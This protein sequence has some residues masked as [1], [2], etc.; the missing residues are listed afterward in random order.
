[1]SANVDPEEVQAI[2]D[3]TEP[4]QGGPPEVQ[5]RD[6]ARPIRLSPK[7][8]G[9][10]EV[11]VRRVL[12]EVETALA[13]ALRERR[14]LNLIEAGEVNSESTFEGLAEPLAAVRF[15]VGGQPAWLVW[16]LLPALTAVEVALG[17]GE[18]GLAEERPFSAVE[19]KV[20]LRLAGPLIAAVCG[21]LNLAPAGLRVPQTREDLGSWRD[22]GPGADRR[23]L[24]L[25]L[26]LDGPGAPS[27]LR[28]Y[29]PGIDPRA[30]S[31]S[32]PPAALPAHLGPIKIELAAR[33]GANDIPL[34]Q[35]LSLEPGDVIPLSAPAG[36]PLRVYFEDRLRA[37]GVLG[38]KHGHLALRITSVGPE[39]EDI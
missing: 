29:L 33:L 37:H 17:A 26:E 14:A 5:P 18:P 38:S 16:E 6:F 30:P 24:L 23:R 22:G 3:L 8:L 39:D 4:P 20:L 9:A 15:E 21:A 35:L 27:A 12:P 7:E 34:A 32:G 1:V 19:R 13:R 31:P 28:L 25:H 11:G 2:L 36:E 10:I